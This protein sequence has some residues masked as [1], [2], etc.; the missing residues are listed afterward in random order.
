MK[1]IIISGLKIILALMFLFLGSRIVFLLLQLKM[2]SVKYIL[3]G[4]ISMGVGHI[5]YNIFES[6]PSE[7]E[8]NKI[9]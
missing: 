8:E 1:S 9:K 5:A 3:I 2:Y 4:I 7:L 6:I